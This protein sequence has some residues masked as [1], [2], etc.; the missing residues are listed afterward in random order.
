MCTCAAYST[1]AEA[2][3]RLIDRFWLEHPQ[4]FIVGS[5]ETQAGESIPFSCDERDWIT[6]AEESMLWLQGQGYTHCY[7]ILDDHPPVGVCNS[8]Y[9]NAVLPQLM[10]DCGA[11]H[12]ALSGWDQF[13]P[14]NGTVIQVG[15]ERWLHNDPSF[16]WKFDLHPGIWNIEDF[17]TLLQAVKKDVPRPYSAREFEGAAGSKNLSA[18][19]ALIESTYKI[20][21]DVMASGH[22]WWERK[23]KRRLLINALHISRIAARLAGSSL[24]QK[25]DDQTEQ[26]TQYINGPYPM[27]WSGVIKK[28][29]LNQNLIKFAEATHHNE[30]VSWLHEL[31]WPVHEKVGKS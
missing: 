18:P 28:G 15:S 22:G 4:V 17:L 31:E 29:L 1:I 6:M 21:G 13:Q 19:Q 11:S 14:K 5:R 10:A 12:V 3:C 24:V 16:K 26:Y 25:L 8:T 7:L 30:L 23:W 27:Y 9:L 20:E 2:S